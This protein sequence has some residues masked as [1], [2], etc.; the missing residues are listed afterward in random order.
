MGAAAL[1]AGWP[2]TGA[3]DGTKHPK[4]HAGGNPSL[5]TAAKMAG[6]M[7][8]KTPTAS[9]KVRS[10][11]F[12]EGRELS[13]RELIKDG[14]MADGFPVPM[15]GHVVLSTEHSR[16]LMGFPEAWGQAAPGRKDYDWMQQRL[17]TGEASKDTA[18]P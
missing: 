8:P 9:D 1:L 17:S 13:A 16:W 12:Q 7:T 10:E 5:E 18:T 4:W 6:W 3:T 15:G 11:R 14:G 2:T